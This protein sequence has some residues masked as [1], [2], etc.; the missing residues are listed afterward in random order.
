MIN[1]INSFLKYLG[2][3]EMFTRVHKIMFMSIV[4]ISWA[5]YI[6]SVVA[7]IG[8]NLT[9]LSNIIQEIIK[10]YMGLFLIIKYNPYTLKYKVTAFDRIIVFQAGCFILVSTIINR[11]IHQ[12]YHYAKSDIKSSYLYHYIVNDKREGV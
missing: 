3:F 6:F 7:H 1:K 11:I 4:Y 5:L 10:I 2:E 12:Y 9:R 8:Y